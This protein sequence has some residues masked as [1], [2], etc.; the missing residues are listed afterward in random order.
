MV[1]ALERAC[2]LIRSDGILIVVH[3]SPIPPAIKIQQGADHSIA[4]W[5]Y[6]RERFPF[7][8]EAD[9]AVEE[10]LQKGDV[11]LLKHRVFPY[12]TRISSYQGFQEW[13]EQQWDTS[14]LPE[15]VDQ[16]IQ[17]RFL[18]GSP[19]TAVHILNQGN[20]RSLRVF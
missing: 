14:Y 13:L 2:E 20:I 10:V 4:G 16:M 18:A 8:R 3:D 12:L 9:A 7:I 1:H 11:S 15:H 17:S 5:L 19:G 6:D